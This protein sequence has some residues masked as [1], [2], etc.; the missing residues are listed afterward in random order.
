LKAY[1]GD[2]IQHTI[3]L[4]EGVQPFR[5]KQR[6]I[7]PKLAPLIQKELQNMLDA[8]I[9]APIRHSSWV[10]NLVVV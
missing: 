10:A 1:K 7:N 6:N 3:P 5:Q 4:K 8:K 9:I 2:I